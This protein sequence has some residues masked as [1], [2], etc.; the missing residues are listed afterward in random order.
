MI[1]NFIRA[2]QAAADV[3]GFRIVKFAD[4]TNGSTV[5]AADGAAS[6]VL[7]VSDSL[8]ADAGGMLDVQMGG[9]VSV[10]LGGAVSAGDPLMSD[11]DGKAIDATAAAAAA[12]GTVRIVG[13]AQE[14]GAADD[15][16][17]AIYAPAILH[18]A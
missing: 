2:Y 18:Q 16:I 14:P 13:F 11:A 15:I 9:L 4:P 5:A 12:S 17:G 10:Q 7:G 1:P 3:E 8:G 6:E